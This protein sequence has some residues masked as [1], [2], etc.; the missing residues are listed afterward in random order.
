MQ[1]SW[2]E[3]AKYPHTGFGKYVFPRALE[4]YWSTIV[5][6]V[7]WNVLLLLPAAHIIVCSKFWH[8][9]SQLSI[10][11]IT[12]LP[13]SF[14]GSSLVT[15]KYVAAIKRNWT[16]SY[17]A[18][19]C[20]AAP[21][22]LLCS[23]KVSIA[24][25]EPARIAVV[26]GR[27]WPCNFFPWCMGFSQILSPSNLQ[28]YGFMNTLFPLSSPA[29]DRQWINTFTESRSQTISAD[30]QGAVSGFF[31]LDVISAIWK[32]PPQALIACFKKFTI[33]RI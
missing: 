25:V 26:Q 7:W 24:G 3:N 29:I 20:L 12:W 2:T 10:A 14:K 5:Q 30:P 21:Y 28:H 1:E 13:H 16:P 33:Q 8:V 4:K 19:F 9:S 6:V 22:S 18:S 15:S 31:I 23:R 32:M 17:T 11:A 27:K